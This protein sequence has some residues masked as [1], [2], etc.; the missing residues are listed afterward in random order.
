VG[1]EGGRAEGRPP[2]AEDS[3]HVPC[4]IVLIGGQGHGPSIAHGVVYYFRA[5]RGRGERREKDGGKRGRKEG[6]ASRG[7]HRPRYTRVG[8]YCIRLGTILPA[9]ASTT[10]TKKR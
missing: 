10:G 1:G 3:T 2:G 7:G 8:E 9:R 5:R 4:R 6:G